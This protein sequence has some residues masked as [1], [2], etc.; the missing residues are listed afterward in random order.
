MGPVQLGTKEQLYK[1]TSATI[2]KVSLKE[3]DS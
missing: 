3:S 1:H 2:T